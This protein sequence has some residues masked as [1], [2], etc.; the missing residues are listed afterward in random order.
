MSPAGTRAKGAF[1]KIILNRHQILNVMSPL[2]C[3]VSGKSTV[4]AIEGVLIEASHP[5]VCKFT[6][7][8]LEKGVST[9]TS[10][11]VLEEGSYIINAQKMVQTL[12][13]MD[14]DEVTLSVDDKLCAT[15]EFGKS[16]H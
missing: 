10:A 12:R 5:D 11:K 15:F 13:V 6:T 8:D 4:T 2:M 3:A 14:G 1:M 16:S 9:V 7:Y